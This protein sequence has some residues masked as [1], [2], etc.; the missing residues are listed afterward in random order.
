MIFRSPL[1]ATA[2]GWG[3][4]LGDD[5]D[6]SA[7]MTSLAKA[8]GVSHLTAAS[9]ANIQLFQSTAK[10]LGSWFWGQW[11]VR[12]LIIPL[13]WILSGPSGSLWRASLGSGVLTA[14]TLWG[15]PVLIWW[16]LGLILI[17]TS[18]TTWWSAIGF[19]LSW[20]AVL[21]LHVS[22]RLLPGEDN[23]PLLPQIRAINNFGLGQLIPGTVI[24]LFVSYPLWRLFGVWQPHG[25]FATLLTQPFLTPYIVIFAVSVLALESNRVAFDFT[26]LD[27]DIPM[28]IFGATASVLLWLLN[29]LGSIWQ[30][31]AWI[32]G[33]SSNLLVIVVTG[34]IAHRLWRGWRQRRYARREARQWGWEP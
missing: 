12:A 31:S 27:L 3:L 4:V 9:G 32:P 18:L 1:E 22:Q 34:W 2:L 6:F 10:P 13:Y 19:W 30:F 14:A 11:L 20:L 25:V 21:G 8:A 7:E 33:W 23:H 28:M 26:R 5:Q 16:L 24:L 17:T 15:R 29:V